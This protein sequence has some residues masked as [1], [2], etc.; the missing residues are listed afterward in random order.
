MSKNKIRGL[1]ALLVTLTMVTASSVS[2]AETVE[3]SGNTYGFA[4]TGG[5][6]YTDYQT[7]D[8]EQQLAKQLAIEAAGEGFVM[9]KNENNALPLKKGSAV[10]LFGMHSISLV[11]S[12]SGSA[13]GRTGANG[14]EESTLRLAME[15]AGFAVNPKL[16]DLYTRHQ[17]LGTTQN[18]LPVSYYS[19]ATVSTYNGYHDAAI[20][21]F[22]RTGSEAADKKASNVADHS[23]PADHE[24]ML[25]DNE[26]A[27]VKHVKQYYPDTPIIVLVNS[28]N[29]LQIPE[30]AEP[31]ATSEYGVDAIF[32]VGNTG[33]NAIE[34]IGKLLSGEVNP[35][36]HT[37]EVWEKDFTKGPT[38]TNFAQQSQNLDADGNPMDA[39]YYYEGEP[40]K[41]ATVE[42][43]EGIYVGYKYYETLYDDAAEAD[44][45]AAYSNVLYPFG[46]GLSYTS[47]D[48]E[49]VPASESAITDAWQKMS[50]QVKVTNTGK[51]AGK[52][53]VQVYANPPYT[54]GGI[55]KA[56]ANLVGFAKTE[57]L[58]PGE[59]ET[60]TIQWVAQDMASFDWND[61]NENSFIGYELEGGAYEIT[62][63]R[64]SHD[65]VL[66]ETYTVDGGIQCTKDYTT[67]N[68]ITALFVDD[69]ISVNDSLLSGMISRANG[70]QQP[71]PSSVE[72]RTIDAD[73]L[74]F[75]DN[76]YTY[77]SY[78]DQGYEDW[79]VEEAGIPDT[80]TQKATRG[81]TD[82][83]AISILDMTGIDFS[84]S[85]KDGKVVQGEDEGSKKWEAFMNQLTWEE[86]A[87]LVDNGGGV[88]AIPAV[89][90]AYTGTSETPLQLA[91]GTMWACPPILAASFN[92]ELAERVGVMMGNEALF[93]GC[94]YWQGNAMNI[95]RS[96]LSGRNVE[97]YSQDG[98]H[99]GKF[100][101]AV[102]K[103]VTSKGVTCQI[104][105]MMLND[106]ESYRDLNGGVFVWATEQVIRE[107]YAKP[108][109]YALKSGNSTG[110]MG[111]F[112]RI[113]NMNSQLNAALH[114]L[115]RTEWGN[116]AI[117]ETDAWQGTYCPVDLMVRQGDNQVLGS[118]AAIPDV[119]LEYGA[120]DAEGNC[121]RVSD[122]GEGTFL[123]QT[124]YAA[125]RRSAQEILWNFCN[126]NGIKNGY[127]DIAPCVLEF[128]KYAAQSLPIVFDGIDY[129][130][131]A[132]A[133][134]NELPAGFTME[135]GIITADGTLAEG[136]WTVN[137]ALSGIDGYI[138]LTAPVVIRLVEPIHADGADSLTV[139]QAA[140]VTIDAPYYAY[141]GYVA[142]NEVYVNTIT[143]AEGNS[144]QG[145]HYPGGGR[146]REG[147]AK[148][149][150]DSIGGSWRILNW[151]WKD[152]SQLPAGNTYDCVG[153]L[154][155]ADIE[156]TDAR[157]LDTA[158]VLAG[159]YYK[160]F[161]YEFSISDEDVAKLA[162]Y[163]LT[164]EKIMTSHTGYQG[165]SYDVNTGLKLSGTPTKAGTVEVSVTVQVPLCVGQRFPNFYAQMS[166]VVTEITSPITVVIAE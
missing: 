12:T 125:V 129:L 94:A 78:M 117:F 158:D 77:R 23:N 131:V 148:S 146:G 63:R 50:M 128:D 135:E 105:H 74:A 97:Y 61:A 103:G 37:V 65:V 149:T 18:E 164:V 87:K 59:S 28:S 58:Q 69:S 96:S 40:T 107:L 34:A 22:S 98:V 68:D 57:L 100:A 124:H 157:Y 111:S 121:V 38:W 115:V 136:E 41:Y 88:Q 26:K 154:A 7:L 31:K 113:G 132:L 155:F 56:S 76:Q 165:I 133:E 6:Y 39:Y 29:I 71:A 119:G 48:W 62:A 55:E 109:E 151:Y 64:N 93:K 123:S 143:D 5:K 10:S 20:L 152:A 122:G 118:G 72:D 166:P 36:G 11:A 134:G 16:T 137:V 114:T 33:N 139:G 1:I 9:L 112:N 2:L 43:R 75:I 163:G 159:N 138:N 4:G 42:Y 104:K 89:G 83:E 15:K 126:G 49:L 44:K 144:V 110:V 150:G 35:S 67:G 120:W 156:A 161:P 153:H 162:E 101:A 19:N 92:L 73:Y 99:G 90:V 24:L 82:V 54:K 32:W 106:Q 25:D 140:D 130:T 14:I 66:K 145:Q 147:D 160:A 141:N 116:R 30:L 3:P 13:A 17:T 80:W 52:D 86:M 53:V 84:L 85:I 91:N 102:A 127:S 8:E 95:H 108:F 46:Y 81:E 70:L 47:F 21:V 27:L 60:V 45:E 51:V 142:V 79:F